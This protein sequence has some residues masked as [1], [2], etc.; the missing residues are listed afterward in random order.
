MT[1]KVAIKI[2][3]SVC[4]MCSQKIAALFC[5]A[6]THFPLQVVRISTFHNEAVIDG[7]LCL[8]LALSL[9]SLFSISG[10]K[11]LGGHVCGC[12][13][14]KFHPNLHVG[15]DVYTDSHV[16]VSNFEALDQ[17]SSLR[18]MGQIIRLP[19]IL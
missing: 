15:V 8:A 16:T 19:L 6:L 3:D 12:L 13:D 18:L 17:R 1:I 9:L 11:C 5:F 2:F 10:P 7:F 4:G 14:A